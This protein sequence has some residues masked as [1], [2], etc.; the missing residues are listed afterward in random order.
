M[1]ITT[2]EATCDEIQK[3]IDQN[4]DKP[5]SVRIFLAGMGCSGPSLG[6]GLDEAKE[7]DLTEEH[8]GVTFVM[9]EN[10]Y[11]SM[12]EIMVEFKGDGYLVQPKVQQ[13]SACSSCAGSCDV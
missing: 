7:D 4:T 6:L 2:N 10:I 8:N 5:G 12:G 13:P 1:Y 9:Q 3:I 11:D